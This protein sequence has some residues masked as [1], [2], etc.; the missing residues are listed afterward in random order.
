MTEYAAI[1]ARY[2]SDRQ[3]EESIT[4]Q[5]RVCKEYATR[6]EIKI[7][8][9]YCDRAI[10]G[11]AAE[12]RP[13]FLRMVKDSEKKRFK[14][15]IVYKLDRFARNRYDSAMFKNKLKKNGVK[16]LSATE[17]ISDNPEG[18]ILESVL[19]GMAEFYSAELSQKILRGMRESAMQCRCIN[20]NVPLGYTVD[21]EHRY[22]IDEDEAQLVREIFEDYCRGLTTKA[23]TDDLN[24]RGFKTKKGNKWNK[25]SI[26][27]ILKNEKYIGIYR[28]MDI[29][30][31]DGIPAIVDKEL[32]DM[33]QN[34]FKKA[35]T[36]SRKTDVDFLLTSKLY[37]GECGSPM[38]GDSGTSKTNAERHY[39][40]TCVSRKRKRSC[41]KKSVRKDW[42]ERRVVEAT[43]DEILQTTKIINIA[44]SVVALQAKE[45]D[46]NT[47]LNSLEA[48][49]KETQSKLC[50]LIKALE[51]GLQS[52][53]VL[54]KIKQY[55]GD[56]AAIEKRIDD[57]VA[58]LPNLT[59]WEIEYFL[60]SFIGG[61]ISDEKYRE[62]V[63]D[64]LISKVT[65][66]DNE[67]GGNKIRI[68]YNLSTPD[69]TSVLKGSDTHQLVE[70][71][72]VEP[73]SESL[74]DRLST[75]LLAFVKFPLLGP[76]PQKP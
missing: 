22:Q 71:A 19:E 3:R 42:I 27:S 43:V 38:V 13:E 6:H 49:H 5:L 36:R 30:V 72:G 63:I 46:E 73:A 35:K 10:S 56:L 2:S 64:T 24:E 28:Y 31:K 53:T 55:E 20:G 50:N 26:R 62:R 68:R 70:A 7:V 23:I 16:V 69:N 33:V 29:V 41:S 37:C 8:E 18:I 75:S 58:S 34:R 11:K 12:N 48:Q 52:D 45:R 47:L 39:Y 14:Y 60:N 17:N 54:S 1:Y 44:K 67:N 4:A 9:E 32:F 74:P 57:A 25:N 40:Y 59:E 15:V 21:L 51:K 66:Y 76:Q 65:L 61:D